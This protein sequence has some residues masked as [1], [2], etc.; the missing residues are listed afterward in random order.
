VILAADSRLAWA[1]A[2]GVIAVCENV[3]A[4]IDNNSTAE[5]I[6]G[7]PR[8]GFAELRVRAR[9]YPDLIGIDFS[10][11]PFGF[12]LFRK[13]AIDVNIQYAD[14][15]EALAELQLLAV[16]QTPSMMRDATIA[17]LPAYAALRK[18]LADDLSK[19]TLDAL[20]ELRITLKRDALRGVFAGDEDEN[21]SASGNSG[22]ICP[23]NEESFVDGG[24]YVGDVIRKFIGA[25]NGRYRSID[26]F[27]PDHNSFAKLQKL[28]EL[29]FDRIRLH[30]CALGDAA[31]VGSFLQTGTMSSHMLLDEKSPANC[32]EN[33]V[34]VA[35]LDDV[36]DR[37]TLL[38]LDLEGFEVPALRGGAELIRRC[39]PRM[40]ISAYH[41]ADDL[42]NI[43]ATVDELMPDCKIRL[44][45]HSLYYVT[46]NVYAE[47]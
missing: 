32:Q 23:H 25:T 15:V 33:K 6:H 27:E 10:A 14:M 9:D 43:C 17:R 13:L 18:R 45:H 19:R 20:I 12:A 1:R 34:N 41:Y 11:R 29:P 7:K 24:A 39:R 42:L 16:Y 37:M 46:T 38:K 31:G 3:V 4:M 22:L 30:Q 36:V 35:R 47:P 40:A 8:W 2:P 28:R 44:R 26:A 5:I 21:F